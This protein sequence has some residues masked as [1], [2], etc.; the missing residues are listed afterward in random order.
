MDVRVV[1]DPA[2]HAAAVIARRLRDAVRRRGQA[3]VAFSGGSTTPPMLT[4][5]AG[6]DVPWAAVQVFQVDERVAPDGHADRNV[7]QLAVLPIGTTQLHPMPVTDTNLDMAAARYASSLPDRFD[8]VH[9]GMGDDGHTASWP[10]GDPVVRSPRTV[11]V[12]GP[13]NG[14]VRMTLTPPAVAA[15]RMRLVLVTGA[16]KAPMVARWIERDPALP[17]THVR[18]SG[19]LVLLDGAAASRLP[20]G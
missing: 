20:A 6:L 2:A 14:R 4:A 13:F 5:L 15:A 19:T 16:S 9:L 10:P 8:V 17:V 3:T 1:D 18:R 7:G 12:C 11:D